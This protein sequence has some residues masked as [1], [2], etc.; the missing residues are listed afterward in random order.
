MN[1]AKKIILSGLTGLML[2]TPSLKPAGFPIIA[3]AATASSVALTRYCLGKYRAMKDAKGTATYQEARNSFLFWRAALVLTYGG[4]VASWY[5]HMKQP[6]Q[7]ESNSQG[8]TAKGATVAKPSS[9]DNGTTCILR[10]PDAAAEMAETGSLVQQQGTAGTEN[11]ATHPAASSALVIES[12]GEQFSALSKQLAHKSLL[13]G[14]SLKAHGYPMPQPQRGKR[15]VD[16]QR[17]EAKRT[18]KKLDSLRDLG[19]NPEAG[20]ISLDGDITNLAQLCTRGVVSLDYSRS[21]PAH[22]SFAYF[23]HHGEDGERPERFFLARAKQEDGSYRHAIVGINKLGTKGACF[24]LI[25][26]HSG[27]EVHEFEEE[28]W[29]AIDLLKL[30]KI[31]ESA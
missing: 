24:N 10:K 27:P 7:P 13:K 20:M 17:E 30:G 6:R 8:N 12:M 15:Y 26:D 29:T 5:L 2:L 14:T 3:G 31:S 23:L 4:T 16:L 22:G 21:Y 28:L 11:R 9:G 25:E 1:T 19:K 18:I